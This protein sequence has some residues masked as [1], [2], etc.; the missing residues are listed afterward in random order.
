ML[1]IWNRQYLIS[2]GEN[3]DNQL[4]CYKY[5]VAAKSRGYLGFKTKKEAKEYIL[6]L[7]NKVIVYFNE[8]SQCWN[9][10]MATPYVQRR[11][12]DK[13]YVSGRF[14]IFD[15]KLQD[16]VRDVVSEKVRYSCGVTIFNSKDLCQVQN[17]IKQNNLLQILNI[18]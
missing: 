2:K 9:I 11:V 10:D 12:I 8:M 3:L 7:N 6:T 16:I 13:E 18:H 5:F 1:E 15:E 4:K 17:F 14:N